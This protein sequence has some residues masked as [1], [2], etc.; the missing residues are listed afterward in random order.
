MSTNRTEWKDL[1][2]IR[3]QIIMDSMSGGRKFK[4][5]TDYRRARRTTVDKIFDCA[6]PN[7][8]LL[9]AFCEKFHRTCR[10]GLLG[11]RLSCK[12]S[13]VNQGIIV[14]FQHRTAP[15]AFRP[16]YST[17]SDITR[18]SAGQHEPPL[19][20]TC[21]EVQPPYRSQ[22]PYCALHRAAPYVGVKYGS[23]GTALTEPFVTFGRMGHHRSRNV[24]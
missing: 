2:S 9:P 16:E 21:H 11:S 23:H 19:P 22:P 17:K 18:R 5:L 7:K 8:P 3:Q 13:Q 4:L 24:S 1:D 6:P 10:A 20:Y 12:I 15:A 14:V